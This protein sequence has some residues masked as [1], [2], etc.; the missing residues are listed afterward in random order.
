MS[1]TIA[2]IKAKL[3]TYPLGKSGK[4]VTVLNISE[5]DITAEDNSKII[6]QF[7]TGNFSK[8]DCTHEVKKGPSYGAFYQK[9]IFGYDSNK[10]KVEIAKLKFPTFTLNMSDGQLRVVQ[11]KVK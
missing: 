5:Q 2:E 8:I 3:Q 7:A 9:T 1:A 10:Q 6:Q 11:G 4:S